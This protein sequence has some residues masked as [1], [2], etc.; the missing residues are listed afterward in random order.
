MQ[1]RRSKP[2]ESIA[3]KTK[4]ST[5]EASSIT[6]RRCGA[7]WPDARSTL[8]VENPSPCQPGAISTTAGLAFRPFEILPPKGMT[9]P[10]RQRL[11][12]LKVTLP[13][14]ICD[15]PVTMHSACGL[16]SSHQRMIPAIQ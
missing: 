10:S 8:V 9:A 2:S 7:C 11:I 15:G 13:R 1:T 5:P 3:S 14:T 12:S 4:S 6:A 16:V